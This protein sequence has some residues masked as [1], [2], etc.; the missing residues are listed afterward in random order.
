MRRRAIVLAT[1]GLL[2][3]TATARAQ[4]A[5]QATPTEAPSIAHDAG[6]YC[7]YVK[8]VA[9][10]LAALEMAPTAF[11]TGGIVSAQDISPG[12]SFVGPA[13]RVIAG[14]S[15]SVAGLYRG[16]ALRSGADAECR[17][18]RT[19]SERCMRS[20][21]SNR[22]GLTRGS[23]SAKLSVLKEAMPRAEEALKNGQALL[24]QARMNLEQLEALQIRV[25]ALRADAAQAE[26]DLGALAKAPAPPPVS[27]GEALRQR[28]QAEADEE[29]YEARLRMSHAWDVS[30]RG[31]Y[32]QTF[33]TGFKYV[34]VFA[35]ATV[36]L[37]LG[38]FFQPSAERHATQGR[39]GWSHSQIE[40]ADDRVQQLVMRIRALR[41]AE[42]RRLEETRVL[43]SDLETRYKGL[44]SVPGDKV[45]EYAQY[46]WFDLVRTRANHAYFQAHVADLER[47]LGPEKDA[48]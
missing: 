2:A 42:Q 23:L 45:A 25:D 44:Q 3:T 19:V 26:A 32:D 48:P 28:D 1:A 29:R 22:E 17:R 27:I 15:Y 16:F 31:G 36:S 33:G 46:M 8:G 38:A 47:L 13:A 10:S 39:V 21:E 34:P 30:I 41:D 24:A 11:G 37:N 4:S 14:G 12:V 35:L 40:G 20:L 6:S 18:Y 43:L 5:P 9:N 7:E